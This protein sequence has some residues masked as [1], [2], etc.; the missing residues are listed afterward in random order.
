MT[1]L[2]GDRRTTSIDGPFVTSSAPAPPPP[3]REP[4]LFRAVFEAERAFV[5]RALRAL[6]RRL[7]RARKAPARAAHARGLPRQSGRG[8]WGARSA[9]VE[10]GGRAGAGGAR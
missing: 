8:A 9:G 6:G 1:L 2:E 4:V 5:G 3:R 10:R 7:P